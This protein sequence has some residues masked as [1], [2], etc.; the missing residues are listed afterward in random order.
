MVDYRD[1]CLIAVDYKHGHRGDAAA[2]NDLRAGELP[3]VPH[4]HI[5]ALHGVLT[6]S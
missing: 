6:V 3:S 1:G 2:V 5:A 4:L